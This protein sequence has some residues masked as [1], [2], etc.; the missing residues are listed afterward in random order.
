MSRDNLNERIGAAIQRAAAELPEGF[1]L[2]IEIERN[3][4]TVRLY[5]ADT[6]SSLDDFR[7]DD[8]ADYIEKAI[9]KAKEIAEGGE[10]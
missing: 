6:D 1:D 10:C 2:H 8:F 4:G 5:L 3:A 7:G 9:D